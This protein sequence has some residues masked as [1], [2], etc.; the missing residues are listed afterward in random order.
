MVYVS[1]SRKC[2][3]STEEGQNPGPFFVNEICY[4]MKNNSEI[5]KDL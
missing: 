2:P 1:S 3:S 5:D 4:Q